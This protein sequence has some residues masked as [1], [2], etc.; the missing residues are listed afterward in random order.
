MAGGPVAK[1][2]GDNRPNVLALDPPKVCRPC[3]CWEF[4]AGGTVKEG[5][6]DNRSD[7]SEIESKMAWG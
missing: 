5:G 1:G 7:G 2:D 3:P 6:E 4:M